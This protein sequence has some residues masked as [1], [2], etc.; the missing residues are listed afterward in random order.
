MSKKDKQTP[1]ITREEIRSLIIERLRTLSPNKEISIGSSGSYSI[2][3]L[4]KEVEK[5][6]NVG[7]KIVRI[8]LEFLQSL[9]DLPVY[10]PK[11]PFNN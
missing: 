6:S 1:K 7:K 4:I 2:E 3:E 11:G 5:G 9:K 8:E 10:E